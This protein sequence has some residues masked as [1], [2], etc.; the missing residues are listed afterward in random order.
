[1]KPGIYI[2]Y[3]FLQLEKKGFSPRTSEGCRTL[4]FKITR[5]HTGDPR[6]YHTIG[7]NIVTK[8]ELQCDCRELEL[9]SGGGV[10]E[11]ASSLSNV[12]SPWK[13]ITLV[14]QS[15]FHPIFFRESSYGKYLQVSLKKKIFNQLPGE[16]REQHLG[17]VRPKKFELHKI[18]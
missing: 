16:P 2:P 14:K 17:D 9:T 6:R 1:M 5:T 3:L 11:L 8:S 7:F 18:P 15:S 4:S 13:S 12:V 10:Y